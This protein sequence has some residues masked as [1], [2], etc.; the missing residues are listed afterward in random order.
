MAFNEK[1]SDRIRETLV[2]MGVLEVEEKHMFGG[3]CYM[4]NDKMC[5]GVI[6]ED[7]M[8]RVEPDREE[9]Y[10]KMKGARPMDFAGRPMKGYVYISEEGL[11]SKKDMDF[12][13]KQC[14]DYN[15]KANAS[16]KRAT[17]KKSPN[18]GTDKK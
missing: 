1:I 15:P 5:V 2:N 11:R 17:K 3:I 9:E 4:V 14:L 7:M 16:K 6:K 12:W 10:L 13:V 8:C 18:N